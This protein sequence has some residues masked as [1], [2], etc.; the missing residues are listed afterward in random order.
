MRVSDALRLAGGVRPDTYLGRVLIT[1]TRPDS[2]RIQLAAALQDTAGA[3]VNDVELQANDEIRVFGLT[4][5]RP[6][7]YVAITGAVRRGGRYPFR[8]GM[9]M[10]DLILLAGGLR[11]SA[12]LR[13]AEIARL[14]AGDRANGVTAVPFRA[15]MDST[16]LF[17]R[18]PDG[19]YVGPPGLPAPAG[20]TPETV[21]APYDNVLILQQPDWELQRT[22]VLTGEVRFPGPYA[23]ANKSE[24]LT[25][26]IARA[27]GLTSEAYAEGVFFYRKRDRLGR[28]GIDLPRALRQPGHRDNLVLADGDSVHIPVYNAVVYVSGAVNSPVAVSYVPG[29]DMEYYISAAGGPS[30]VADLRR[31]YVTQPNGKVESQPGRF[32]STFRSVEPRPGSRV[33]VP[34]RNLEDRRELLATATTVAQ[35]LASLI[36]VVAVLVNR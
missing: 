29:R 7:R 12:Y 21:L 3:V 33:F 22:V 18:G 30:R 5:F 6:T 8:E 10:R 14:P 1:R 34:E 23:I 17:E 11:E 20:N 28:V 35:I 31:A 9:T 13:E 4:E 16:Y 19:K 25:D 36:T 24:R 27:G 15:P 2:S 26:L 32:A